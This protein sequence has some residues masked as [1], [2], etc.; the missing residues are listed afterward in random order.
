MIVLDTHVL[1]WW[2]ANPKKLSREVRKSIKEEK[3]G[4][5]VSSISVWEIYLLVKKGRLKL[6]IDVDSWLAK[7][8]SL[9]LIRFVPVNNR[10]AAKSVNLPEKFH[11]DPAD[12]II[13]A[14]ARDLGATLLTNDQRIR[15]YSHV[16]TLW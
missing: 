2:V 9:P 15:K 16:Q 12:R 14:T 6:T 5:L 4:I 10:I 13:V 1:I 3:E 8:E 11:Q 7:V